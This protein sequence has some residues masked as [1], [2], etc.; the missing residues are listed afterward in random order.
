MTRLKLVTLA[1]FAVGVSA[2][3][4]TDLAALAGAALVKERQTEMKQMGKAFKAV[5]P[6]LKGEN[7]NVIDAMPSAETWHRN[8]KKIAANF[9]PGT[10]R[11]AVPFHAG[12]N[13]E[14]E[15]YDSWRHRRRHP[16]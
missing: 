7:T 12:S 4:T 8:A 14:H 10:G 1:I 13:Q 9:P 6:I 3:M 5:I 2:L 15:S 16:S 11:E